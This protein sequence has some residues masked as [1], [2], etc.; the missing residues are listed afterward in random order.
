MITDAVSEARHKAGVL[1]EALPWL[2]RFT[3][4]TVVIKFGGHAMVDDEL[5]AAF[6][7]DIVFLHTVGIRPVIV[8]GGGPQIGALLK[9]LD[10]P[11][12]FQG[13]LR[14]TT[15]EVLEIVRMVLVGEV[16][17]R[18][19][20]AINQHGEL[21]VGLS[22]EDAGLLSG[23]KVTTTADGTQ[24]DLGAV[25]EVTSVNTAS[26]VTLLEAGHIPVVATLASDEAGGS[27]NV[28]ADTGAAAVA[29]ALGAEKLVV[30]TDVDGLY[31]R[32]PDPASR[33]TRL[34]ATHLADL[35]PTLSDGMAPKMQA[36]LAAVR[37]GV[38]AAHVLD[39]RLP[40]AVLLEVF[41]DSGVGT[42]VMPDEPR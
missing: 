37:G 20:R 30:L 32:W 19:V 22:G 35:L 18:L 8:H 38:H 13:G 42:M 40:H 14:V 3:D 11:T 2:R 24:V 29:V 12:E 41:T 7:A 25:G 6:A 26:L 28:N 15:P 4:S 1:I 31:A 33:I 21:A 17:P 16:G 5:T 9:K 36:C 27:L 39:G 23:Q 10:I 34:S